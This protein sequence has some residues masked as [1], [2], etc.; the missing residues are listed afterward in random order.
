MDQ[1]KHW[2]FIL[3]AVTV[4]LT[5]LTM[6]AWAKD[7][8]QQGKQEQE[9]QGQGNQ[10]GLSEDLLEQLLEPC[11]AT[12]NAEARDCK[13]TATTEAVS[14]IQSACAEQITA[15]QKA[16]TDEDHSQA[17]R[18]AVTALRTCAQ[19]ALTVLPTAVA[20]CRDDRKSCVAE[21]TAP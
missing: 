1:K 18:D 4:S 2:K 14:S 15:A 13:A 8:R 7:G 20:T 12:C 5:S 19:P 21:C 10:G 9:H 3:L 6:F 11:Q 17:C 16:C